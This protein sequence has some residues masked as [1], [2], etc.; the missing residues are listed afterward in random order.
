MP[1][2]SAWAQRVAN[3]VQ[4]R[5]MDS[6]FFKNVQLGKAGGPDEAAIVNAVLVEDS[7]SSSMSLLGFLKHLH[8]KAVGK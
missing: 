1:R 2:E 8:Q 3:V 5:R 7:V 6:T 4:G